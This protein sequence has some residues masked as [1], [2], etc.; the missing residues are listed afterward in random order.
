[1]LRPASPN[2]KQA[3]LAIEFRAHGET[4]QIGGVQPRTLYKYIKK[5]VSAF[6]QAGQADDF[7]GLGASDDA[8]AIFGEPLEMRDLRK[9]QQPFSSRNQPAFIVRLYVILLNFDPLRCI[10]LHDRLIVLVPDGADGVLD[11]LE[12]LLFKSSGPKIFASDSEDDDDDDEFY[13]QHRKG[14]KSTFPFRA[15]DAV[16]R[17]VIDN[18]ENELRQ[19]YSEVK[20]ATEWLISRQA[21]VSVD[22]LDKL[23]VLKNQ[24]ASYEA[25]ALMTRQAFEEVLNDDEDMALM[26]FV[27]PQD[28]DENFSSP[29]TPS[30][31]KSIQ[32][33]IRLQVR[34]P[35]NFSKASAAPSSSSARPVVV[36]VE[37]HEVF[38]ILFEHHLQSVSTVQTSFDLLRTELTNGEQFHILRLTTARNK[39][40]TAS[41]VFT[42]IAMWTG[43]GSFVGSIFGMNLN[44]GLED[45]EYWFN[46]VAIGTPFA[47]VFGSLSVVLGLR[48]A[49]VLTSETG[50]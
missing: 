18:L 26:C 3:L 21:N 30:A 1:M 24:V 10:V 15:V 48:F 13:S 9:L 23:R 43:I 28:V 12:K 27:Q 33:L 42:I 46:A 2:G 41:L 38:E 37:D 31:S 16:I 14:S 49:G 25:K 11:V 22:R 8:G 4:S 47:I 7:A 39:L 5:V 45:K 17:T 44:S 36:K 6:A 35:L 29:P 20:E 50:G 19:N 32:N 34:Q 40:L